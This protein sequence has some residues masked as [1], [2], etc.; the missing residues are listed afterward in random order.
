MKETELLSDLKDWRLS[1]DMEGIA[2][3]TFDR[4]VRA[5]TR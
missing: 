2:W 3:A 5:L 4:E 1:L